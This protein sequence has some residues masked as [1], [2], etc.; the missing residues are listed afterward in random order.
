MWQHPRAAPR[1][2]DAGTARGTWPLALAAAL[3]LATPSAHAQTVRT[4][5]FITNGQVTTQVGEVAHLVALMQGR[6]AAA[7]EFPQ[8]GQRIAA[9]A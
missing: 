6:N 4:D 7:T 5:F 9:S 2:S 1:E 8:S 3:A